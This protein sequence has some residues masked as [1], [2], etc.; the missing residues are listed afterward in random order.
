MIVLGLDTSICHFGWALFEISA[1]WERL[2]SCGVIETKPDGGP[3]GRDSSRRTQHIYRELRNTVGPMRP[4]VVVVEALAYVPGRTTWATTSNT[5]RARALADAL[6]VELGAVLLEVQPMRAKEAAT[7][8]RTA[9]K[10]MVIEA[11]CA[12]HAELERSCM[13]EPKRRWE[14]MAD[15][16]AVVAAETNRIQ[17]GFKSRPTVIGE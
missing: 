8:S 12:R 7:G 4:R 11:M 17:T 2:L 14:H 5:G 3:V 1:T 13:R 10:A 15:A 16:C 9:D 6:A